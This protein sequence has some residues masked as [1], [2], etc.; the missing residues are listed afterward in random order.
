MWKDRSLSVCVCVCVCVC[1]YVHD[2]SQPER[3]CFCFVV[4]ISFKGV[5]ETFT[6]LL[7]GPVVVRGYGGG[8]SVCVYLCVY[9]QTL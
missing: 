5:E 9:I 2:G 6:P 7:Q 1:A 4:S 3:V 8:V